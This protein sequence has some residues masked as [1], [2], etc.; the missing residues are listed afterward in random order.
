VVQGSTSE[1]VAW[2]EQVRL[3]IVTLQDVLVAR[4]VGREEATKLGLTPAVLI[5][6]ATAISEIAR[7]VVQHAGSPG[8]IRLGR[9]EAGGRRGLRIIVTDQG[10]GLEHPERVLE[11]AAA[12]NLGAGLPGTRRLADRFELQSSPGAGT[13]VTI[14][15]WTPEVAL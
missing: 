14:E 7:N 15:F 5:R 8:E 1:T 10:R 6:V 11:G 3:P 9:I 12:G 13:T 2:T 4:F